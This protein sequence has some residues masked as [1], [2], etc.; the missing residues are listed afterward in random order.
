VD[1][2]TKKQEKV[3]NTTGDMDFQE[4][5]KSEEMSDRYFTKGLEP[6]FEHSEEQFNSK[7]G[8][9]LKLFK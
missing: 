5:D 6:I 7:N 3:R 4:G 9:H 2:Y 1:K 8:A